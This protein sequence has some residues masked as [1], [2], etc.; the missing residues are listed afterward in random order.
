MRR[1]RLPAHKR[2]CPEC[3]AAAGSGA[4]A[5]VTCCTARRHRR[6]CLSANRVNRHPV[7]VQ[8]LRPGTEALQ[9]ASVGLSM[10]LL[11]CS[12]AAEMPPTPRWPRSPAAWRGPCYGRLCARPT[13]ASQG[14]A[15][16]A[17]LGAGAA[18]PA[19][20]DLVVAAG[21]EFTRVAFFLA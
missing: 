1:S 19:R 2:R 16:T 8:R 7:P 11:H 14:L 12:V 18:A 15:L 10:H 13:R 9:G 6:E 3:D 5:R 17:L 4:P 20:F 21:M